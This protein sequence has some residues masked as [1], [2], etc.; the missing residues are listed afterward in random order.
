[1]QLQGYNKNENSYYEGEKFSAWQIMDWFTD[2]L[3]GVNAFNACNVIKYLIRYDRKGYPLQDL[4]KALN[5]LKNVSVEP[6]YYNNA[7]I[8]ETVIQ[9]FIRTKNQEEEFYFTSALR[10]L[11]NGIWLGK[12]EYLLSAQTFIEHLKE[13]Y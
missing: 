2:N 4:Q 8:I 11:L 7:D 3:Q 12:Q 5:Y 1:M 13:L 6:S 10:Y 9:D